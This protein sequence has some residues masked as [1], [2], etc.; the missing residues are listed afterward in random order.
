MPRIPVPLIEELS[1]TA[2]IHSRADACHH[3]GPFASFPFRISQSYIQAIQDL[4]NLIFSRVRNVFHQDDIIYRLTPE[5]RWNHRA[6]QIAHQHTGW[7]LAPRQLASFF[8]DIP[9]GLAPLRQSSVPPRPLQRL[10]HT[11]TGYPPGAGFRMPVLC[12]S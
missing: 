9:K 2:P 6:C 10:G 12:L 7:T 11:H 4:S 5:G 3:L 1:P 8:R